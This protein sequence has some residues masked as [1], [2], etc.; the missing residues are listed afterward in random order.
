MGKTDRSPLAGN[1]VERDPGVS[2]KN[3]T[4]IIRRFRMP[5]ISAKNAAV[6][7]SAVTV[8]IAVVLVAVIGGGH[9]P[10][11]AADIYIGAD[12]TGEA[13]AYGGVGRYSE[14]SDGTEVSDIGETT[15]TEAPVTDA[16]SAEADTETAAE[17]T[18]YTVTFTFHSRDSISCSAEEAATVSEFAERLGIT[19][20]DADVLNIPLDTVISEDTVITTDKITYG[21]DTVRTVI[22]YTTKYVDDSSMYKGNTNITKYGQNG[23]SVTEYEVKY[24]NGEEVSRTEIKSYVSKQPVEQV[25]KRG[26]AVYTPPVSNVTQSGS[27]S[28]GTFVGGDGKTYRYSSYI[29]VQATVYYSGGYCANGDPADE[30]VIA[31]DPSV[32][33]L[34]TKV[35]ITGDYADIGVRK[36]ADTG[37]S[38][39]GNV[40]DICVNPTSPLAGNFGF[41][42][43]RV[44][45]LE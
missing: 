40:I 26:T 42:P 16:G 18:R 38:I 5:K 17:G 27:A 15:E 28:G 41:R 33:P 6:A 20:T 44:Y 22:P 32:I 29:D 1:R 10:V 3:I 37:G 36:A 30:R 19:F 2:R 25:I 43:M 34:G 4:E 45:I 39:K 35:Y 9:T 21:T 13:E 31:V 12:S 8:C 7:L 14:I 23:E 11:R 24:V